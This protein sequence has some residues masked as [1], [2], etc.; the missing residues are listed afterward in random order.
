M[1]RYIFIIYI[2]IWRRR[3][4][5]WGWLEAVVCNKESWVSDRENFFTTGKIQGKYR[6]FYFENSVG[7]L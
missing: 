3:N 6:E 2:G 5:Y 1:Y 7:T 4:G